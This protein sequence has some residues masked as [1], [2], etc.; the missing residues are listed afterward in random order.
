M[1]KPLKPFTMSITPHLPFAQGVSH[2]SIGILARGYPAK[3]GEKRFA[4]Q[5]AIKLYGHDLFNS[6][7][8]V[9][10]EA[11]TT[12]KPVQIRVRWEDG[13]P[14]VSPV[15]ASKLIMPAGF[16]VN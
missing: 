11:M 3:P 14:I 16:S 12:G 15:A 2:F 1:K 4:S 7:H 10:A 9:Y 13:K 5:E 8:Q 6:M